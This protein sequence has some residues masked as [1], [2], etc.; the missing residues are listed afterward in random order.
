MSVIFSENKYPI[1][2]TISWDDIVEKISKEYSDM[3]H[4]VLRLSF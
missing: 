4:R 1:A 3:N 2:K